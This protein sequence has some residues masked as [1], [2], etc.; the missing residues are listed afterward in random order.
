VRVNVPA[1]HDLDQLQ[2]QKEEAFMKDIAPGNIGNLLIAATVGAA[3]GAGAALLLAPCSG[4][5]TREWLANRSRLL[6]DRTANAFEAGKE[7]TR[8][9]AVELTKPDRPTYV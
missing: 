5:E 8:R 2:L 1:D 9:V 3:V 6:K 4:K 7:A